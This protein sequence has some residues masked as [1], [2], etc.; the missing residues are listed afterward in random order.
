MLYRKHAEDEAAKKRALAAERAAEAARQ[1]DIINSMPTSDRDAIMSLM[2]M[3]NEPQLPSNPYSERMGQLVNELVSNA[4]E[5]TRNQTSE[6][7]LL[8]NLQT[9][10][11]RRIESLT[12]A[13]SATSSN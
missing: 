10:V 11:N 4:P 12:S 8:K 3:S 9:L 7:E 5:D 1:Q 2:A 6:V 13:D